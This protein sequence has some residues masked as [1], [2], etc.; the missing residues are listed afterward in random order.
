MQTGSTDLKMVFVPVGI[1]GDIV[2]VKSQRQWLV[3][4]ISIQKK[5]L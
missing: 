4:E 2:P 1:T 3:T 5:I